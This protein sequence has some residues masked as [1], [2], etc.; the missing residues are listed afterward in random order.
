MT[1]TYSGLEFTPELE[2]FMYQ[3]TRPLCRLEHFWVKKGYPHVKI[4]MY[5]GNEEPVEYL[6]RGEFLTIVATIC[7]RLL[8]PGLQDHAIAPVSL[9]WIPTSLTRTSDY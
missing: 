8:D 7:T 4:G 9:G 3:S 1:H 2:P 6:L 5:H